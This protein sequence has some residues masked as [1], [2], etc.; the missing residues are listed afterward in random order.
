MFFNA[1]IS[2]SRGISILFFAMKS[3]KIGEQV[4]N[5]TIL[6]FLAK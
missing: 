1:L 3:V 2:L 5:L 6:L 4:S